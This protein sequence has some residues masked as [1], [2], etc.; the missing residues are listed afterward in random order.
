MKG[1]M[2]EERKKIKEEKMRSDEKADKE[3][4][5]RTRDEKR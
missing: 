1:Q 5:M 3:K 4:N 2:R